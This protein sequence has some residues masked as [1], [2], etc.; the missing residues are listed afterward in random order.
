M[1]IGDWLAAEQGGTAMEERDPF[2]TLAWPRQQRAPGTLQRRPTGWERRRQRFRPGVVV[3][4]LAVLWLAA[5]GVQLALAG[6]DAR[7]GRAA[8]EEGQSALGAGALAG[9][10][11]EAVLER[12]RTAFA[13]AHGRLTHPLVRPA[14]VIPVLGR[15]LR[16]FTALAGASAQAADIGATAAASAREAL[17]TAA[18]AGPDRVAA[19]RELSAIADEADRSLAGLDLG[20]SD[21]LLAS[22][23]R[24]RDR[25]ADEVAD[26]RS[27]LRRAG[28][29]TAAVADVLAGPSRY[30]LLASNNAEMRAGSGM[31]LSAGLL[32]AREGTLSLGPMRPTGDLTLPGDGI[33][34]D[35]DLQARWGWLHPGREWRNLGL[36]PR[37]DATAELAAAMWETIDGVPVDGVLAI[38][39]ETLRALV[40]A[41]G[42]VPV[43]ERPVGSDQVVD[44]LMH[45]QYLELGEAIAPEEPEQVRRRERMGELAGAVLG[46]LEAGDFEV[47][48][49]A[50]EL[51]G[52]AA[53]RHLLAWSADEGHQEA[54]EAAGI[55]GSLSSH[56]LLVSVLNRGG[57]KLDRFLE[58]SSALAVRPVPTGTDVAVEVRLDNRTPAGEPWYVA[59]PAPGSGLAAGDYLGIVSANVPTAAEDVRIDGDPVLAAR[60]PDGPTQMIAAPVLVP[61]GTSRIVVVRFRLPAGVDGVHVEPSARIPPMEW[62][63]DQA[64]WRGD[65]VRTVAW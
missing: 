4:A 33:Q 19:L 3:A 28:L 47:G 49:L 43:G 20:P 42:P 62:S 41:T 54:W 22:L 45:D 18:G 23:A 55:S 52:A 15:Q 27:A 2:D 13:G 48:T 56:S 64:R 32:E 1:T 25:L 40:A 59:G 8:V 12:A 24:N 6:A 16:S 44:L 30:L 60:G 7:S 63:T 9:T 51:A 57:N 14:L 39:V 10:G 61:A 26:G 34:G 17:E 38:D 35:P 50:T 29:V 11:A 53:G 65:A 36:S 46:A 37:F 5:V 21:H 31:F 58:V